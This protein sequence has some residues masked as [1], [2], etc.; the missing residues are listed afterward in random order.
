[1]ILTLVIICKESLMDKA[2]HLSQTYPP[3]SHAYKPSQV[4][5]LAC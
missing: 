3:R 2:D 5:G 4:L 1:M